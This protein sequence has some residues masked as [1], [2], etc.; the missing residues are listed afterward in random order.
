MRSLRAAGLA[1]LALA[2]GCQAHGDQA[3]ATTD[4]GV[5]VAF[6]RHMT[7]PSEAVLTLV[8]S[9]AQPICLDP[10]T[11]EPARFSVNAGGGPAGAAAA[12]PA[13]GCSPLA[14]GAQVSRTVDSGQTLSRYQIQTGKL[15]YRY[16]FSASDATS[17]RASGQICE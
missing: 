11:F 6:T 10:D 2:A 14:A 15:C 13:S 7:S 4:H 1:L 12:P 9:S 17:W 8:N 5:K 16:S 3:V